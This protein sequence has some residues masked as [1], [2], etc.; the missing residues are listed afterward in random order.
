MMRSYREKDVIRVRVVYATPDRPDREA[1]Q[2]RR[3]AA[4]GVS[5]QGENV[6]IHGIH[7]RVDVD[8][9]GNRSAHPREIHD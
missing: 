5:V 3:T 7:H 4:P 8:V 9:G 2:Q 1:L 6:G